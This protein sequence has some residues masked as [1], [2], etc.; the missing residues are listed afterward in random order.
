MLT[1]PHSPIS[2][3]LHKHYHI[4]PA[5]LLPDPTSAFTS[6]WVMLWGAR[7]SL[8]PSMLKYLSLWCRTPGGT[9]TGQQTYKCWATRLQEI[10]STHCQVTLLLLNLTQ[11]TLS[12]VRD[13]TD[14]AK[15]VFPDLEYRQAS[16]S[17][18]YLASQLHRHMKQ[19]LLAKVA[20][21]LTWNISK[22]QPDVLS[23]QESMCLVPGMALS[24][25]SPRNSSHEPAAVMYFVLVASAAA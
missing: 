2:A 11:A 9:K 18:L 16:P 12:K 21:V 10:S 24:A 15:H 8:F 19:E 13:R 17:C 5:G 23:A 7:L 3:S 14:K 20:P 25:C 4:C 22:L 1:N 6:G